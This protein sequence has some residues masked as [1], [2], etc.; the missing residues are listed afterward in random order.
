MGN[1]VSPFFGAQLEFVEAE[2]HDVGNFARGNDSAVGEAEEVCGSS[3]ERV[4]TFFDRDQTGVANLMSEHVEVLASGGEQLQMSAAVVDVENHVG[5]AERF[6]YV[7]F[8]EAFG[9]AHH[10]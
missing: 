10:L 5:V 2:N 3:G 9:N 1:V 8:A 7:G 4:N 6:D